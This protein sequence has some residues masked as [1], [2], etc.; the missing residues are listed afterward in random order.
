MVNKDLLSSLKCINLEDRVSGSLQ[1][2]IIKENCPELAEIPYC[3][4]RFNENKSV[5][6]VIK[7]II[8][9]IKFFM[10]RVSHRLFNFNL[11]KYFPDL[12]HYYWI[13]LPKYHKQFILDTLNYDKMILKSLFKKEELQKI[14]KLFLKSDYSVKAFVIS[15]MSLELWLKNINKDYK[16]IIN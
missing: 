9:K 12:P 13:W 16:L 3:H 2:Y 15:L 7:K 4:D 14:V 10:N 11:F 5:K 1:K 8:Y 6:M